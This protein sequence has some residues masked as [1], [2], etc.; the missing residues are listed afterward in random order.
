MKI[1][2]FSSGIIAGEIELGDFAVFI[3]L[4]FLNNIK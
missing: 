3:L 1:K 4:A 2:A